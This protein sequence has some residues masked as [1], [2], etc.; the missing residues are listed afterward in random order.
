[1]PFRSACRIYGHYLVALMTCYEVAFVAS[2]TVGVYVATSLSAVVYVAAM[3]EAT[4]GS[5]PEMLLDEARIADPI[6]C[7]FDSVRNWIQNMRVNF[8]K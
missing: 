7:C 4:T 3:E 1:M 5:T 8:A 6:S 2:S